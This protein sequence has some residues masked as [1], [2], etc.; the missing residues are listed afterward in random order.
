MQPFQSIVTDFIKESAQIIEEY[1]AQCL[2]I[3]YEFPE[4]DLTKNI[5]SFKYVPNENANES[6]PVAS[7]DDI[8]AK[9]IDVSKNSPK[10][11]LLTS[12]FVTKVKNN[13]ESDGV[14]AS[15]NKIRKIIEKLRTEGKIEF[16]DFNE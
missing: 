16:P 9:I 13:L 7:D 15:K 11:L 2:A 8:E 10:E 6:L 14:S 5:P 12:H 1:Q 3:A 4:L